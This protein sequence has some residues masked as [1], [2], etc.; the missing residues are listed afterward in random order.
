MPDSSAI[1]NALIAKL[2][3]YSPLL[4]LMPNGVYKN[5]P[6]PGATRFVIVSLVASFDTDVFMRRAFE[7]SLYDVEARALVG[8][9]G[10][11]AAAARVIDDLLA[12]Q[13]VPAELTV[14]GYQLMEIARQEFLEDEEV[15]DRDESIRWKRRGGRYRVRCVVTA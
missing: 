2:G 10:D 4:A 3:A 11:V 1:G 8:S 15:D 9:G 7:E 12:P 13:N 14:P 5:V 6:P